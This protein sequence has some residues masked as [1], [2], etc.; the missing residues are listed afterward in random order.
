MVLTTNMPDKLSW[1]AYKGIP[2]PTLIHK[3]KKN[4]KF[5]KRSKAIKELEKMDTC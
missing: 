1:F 5:W 2:T 4:E 3:D